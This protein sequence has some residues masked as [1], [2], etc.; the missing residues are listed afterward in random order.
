M[1]VRTPAHTAAEIV[2]ATAVL[3]APLLERAR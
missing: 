2:N 1:A 3:R